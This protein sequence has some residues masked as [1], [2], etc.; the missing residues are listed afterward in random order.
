MSAVKRLAEKF[1]KHFTFPQQPKSLAKRTDTSNKS[2]QFQKYLALNIGNLVWK[3]VKFRK[4][5]FLKTL[6][7]LHY[8]K[9]THSDFVVD[10]KIGLSF[11]KLDF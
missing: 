4:T 11:N 2:L 5:I 3:S 6:F 10:V 9:R 7:V 8:E 1:W